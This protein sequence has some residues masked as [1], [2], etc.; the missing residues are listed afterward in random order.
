MFTESLV[1]ASTTLARWS[2]RGGG[3]LMFLGAMTVAV[4]VVLRKLFSVTFGGADELAGYAMAIATTWSFSY[5]LL[6]RGNVRVDALYIHLPSKLGIALDLIAVI[7]LGVFGVLL[8]RYGYEVFATSWDLGSRSNSELKVPLWVPQG[9]WLLG[10]GQLVLTATVLFV[11]ALTLLLQ[12]NSEEFKHLLGARTMAEEAQ[13]EAAYIKQHEGEFLDTP[14]A[15][16]VVAAAASTT[17]AATGE[18]PAAGSKIAA[19][20]G[21]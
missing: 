3:G 16:A 5:V 17:A 15:A 4:D 11:R 21:A 7:G 9:L 12:G 20:K 8:A 10:L 13:T 1:R 18:A 2:V 19:N 6:M 14:A